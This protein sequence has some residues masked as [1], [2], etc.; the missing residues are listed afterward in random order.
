MAIYHRYFTDNNKYRERKTPYLDSLAYTVQEFLYTEGKAIQTIN[1]GDAGGGY[2]RIKTIDCKMDGRIELYD[3]MTMTLHCIN[4]VASDYAK[5]ELKEYIR[6][7]KQHDRFDSRD[8]VRTTNNDGIYI[9]N[10]S[11]ELIMSILWAA[12]IY[13]KVFLD[14]RPNKTLEIRIQLLYDTIK[15]N[16]PCSEKD[17][18]K[19]PLIS[20]VPVAMKLMLQHINAKMK[21][22]K[23]SD[24]S[25][26]NG[27]A[28]LQARITELEAENLQLK[29]A[30][31]TLEKQLEEF[32]CLEFAE[33]IQWHDKVRLE[34]L[35]RL[36]EK[37]GVDLQEVVKARVAEVMQAITKLPISTC[38]NYCTNRDL[39]TE[40]HKEEILKLNSK[41]Q[42]IGISFIL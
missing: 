6:E 39:N 2:P 28:K 15:E 38:K 41:L 35:L 30:N 5:A 16:Y 17:L 26:E 13:L 21:K 11:P 25:E 31:K 29:E 9:K 24:S 8:T 18:K 1:Y 10:A 40:T 19:H 23:H 20:H 42:A 37:D 32:K 22:S 3:F 33:E 12:W 14:F 4:A 36:L 27:D 7:L 34:L